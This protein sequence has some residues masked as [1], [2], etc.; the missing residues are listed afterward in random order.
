MKIIKLKCD[1][2]GAVLE[3][4]SELN[5]ITCNYCGNKMIIDDEATK[6]DRIENAKLKSR[7]SNHEQSMK[8][9]NDNLEY[10]KK[11]NK[12][13][14][15]QDW[16]PFVIVEGFIIGL[17]LISGIV[18]IFT[19]DKNPSLSRYNK[20][21]LGMTYEECQ[22]ILKVEGHRVKEDKDEVVYEWYDVDC[23]DTLL[24]KCKAI[25]HLEFKNN[26]LV[27]RSENGLK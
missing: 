17:L 1:N 2:C 3:V 27:D 10:R 20:L 18:S 23:E 15:K 19:S 4:N 14:L 9:K 6:I 16:L 21:E 24:K 11:V 25:I 22:K 7:K 13:K 5:E 26:K 12:E 8:E